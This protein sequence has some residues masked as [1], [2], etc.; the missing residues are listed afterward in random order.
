MGTVN[1]FRT[2]EFN[3]FK[4]ANT[5]LFL[6]L[7]LLFLNTEKTV[8]VSG[9]QTWI[10]GVEGDHADHHNHGSRYLILSRGNLKPI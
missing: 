2:K 9:I 4:W 3:F 8:G 1:F 5:D 7:F 6:C 10:V